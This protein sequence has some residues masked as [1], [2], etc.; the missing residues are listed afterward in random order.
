MFCILMTS[1]L[2]A[3]GEGSHVA[4]QSPARMIV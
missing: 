2:L 3:T 1:R 4:F